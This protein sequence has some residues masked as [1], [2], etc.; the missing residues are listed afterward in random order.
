MIEEEIARKW[1]EV[2]RRREDR[3]R[4]QG[5][6][7]KCRERIMAMEEEIV[8]EKEEPVLGEEDARMSNGGRR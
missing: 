3:K 4:L 5:G 2:T 1:K 8:S 6:G 7:M